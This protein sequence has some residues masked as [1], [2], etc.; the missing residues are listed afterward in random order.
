MISKSQEESL[1]KSIKIWKTIFTMFF[2][3]KISILVSSDEKKNSLMDIPL[4]PPSLTSW[5]RNMKKESQTKQLI[6]FRKKK[7]KEQRL[8]KKSS[9]FYSLKLRRGQTLNGK[10][11]N[12]TVVEHLTDV[13]NLNKINNSLHWKKGI[14]PICHNKLDIYETTHII[15]SKIM[16]SVSDTEPK[17]TIYV[18]NYAK[19]AIMLSLPPKVP[20]TELQ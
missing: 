15:N 13:R 12:S 14:D 7:E 9:K 17:I 11:E 2:K 3:I 5:E 6:P 4:S 19:K 18:R 10:R 20:L 16:P 8:K 1:K